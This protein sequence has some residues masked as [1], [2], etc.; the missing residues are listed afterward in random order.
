M[1]ILIVDDNEQILSI[2][3]EF[4]KTIKQYKISTA[5]T[6][7]AAVEMCK[8]NNYDIILLDLTLPG[9]NGCQVFDKIKEFNTDTKIVLASGDIES[10]D[11]EDRQFDGYLKKPCQLKTVLSTLESLFDN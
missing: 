8:T 7:E 4:F 2:L 9:I 5:N 11:L 3:E 6:G 10:I 1:N